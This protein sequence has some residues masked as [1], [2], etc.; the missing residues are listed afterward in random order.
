MIIFSC[1]MMLSRDHSVIL[2]RN[3][4]F[5]LIDNIWIERD[6]MLLN[7]SLFR[8]LTL[9]TASKKDPKYVKNNSKG[10]FYLDLCLCLKIIFII[11]FQKLSSFCSMY[12]AKT[13]K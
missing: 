2:D 3:N 9:F 5:L 8:F 11:L 12:S 13:I 10:K 1:N 6:S 4:D 7:F